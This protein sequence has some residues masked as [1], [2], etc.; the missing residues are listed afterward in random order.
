MRRSTVLSLPAQLVIPDYT[1]VTYGCAKISCTTCSAVFS[2][3]TRAWL[4]VVVSYECKML[5]K[6]KPGKVVLGKM[7]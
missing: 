6:H 4:A 2:K 3:F 5:M 7:L 1:H